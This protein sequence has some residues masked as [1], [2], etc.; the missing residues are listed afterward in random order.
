MCLKREDVERMDDAQRR[1]NES[2]LDQ[3]WLVYGPAGTGK[4]I[5]ALN[6]LRRLIDMRPE[7]DHVYVSKSKL[8]AK[9]VKP[10]AEEMGIAQRRIRSYDQFIWRM[11]IDLLGEAP[12]TLPP[13]HKNEIDPIDWDSV[14]PS[15][16]SLGRRSPWERPLSLVIDE[17]QDIDV[18]FFLAARL[19]CVRL[20]VVMDENQKTGLWADTSRSRIAAAL[21]LDVDHQKQLRVNYR[22]PPEI[23][24][25]A[26]SFYRGDKE[27]LAV[28]P[29]IEERRQIEAPPSIRFLP[30]DDEK[31]EV[32]QVGRI[33]RYCADKTGMTVLVVAPSRDQA[34]RVLDALTKRLQRFPALGRL[35]DWSIRIYRPIQGASVTVDLCAPGIVVSTALNSKGTEFDVVFLVDWQS[36]QDD[37][38][39]LYTAIA[40]ARARIEVLCG[41]DE[42]SRATVLAQFSAAL[43]DNLITVAS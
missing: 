35:P 37:A 8:L 12:P 29:P 4:T 33:L 18:G 38:P 26:D 6:R 16:K 3:N 7:E 13:K 9:W 24:D 21:E 27:E 30:F 19:F 10:V 39:L 34:G 11:L 23:K 1:V 41:D 5:L 15:I 36:S 17:A 22:N 43:E 40:R 2:A 20:F 25:L 42:P 14:N 28:L 32:D 31:R